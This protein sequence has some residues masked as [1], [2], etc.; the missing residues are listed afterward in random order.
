MVHCVFMKEL[1]LDDFHFEAISA[2]A[3]VL[4]EEYVEGNIQDEV[5][6]R[7]LTNK[8]TFLISVRVNM[9]L[10]S[11]GDHED[12]S[13]PGYWG[14]DSRKMS[15][16]IPAYMTWEIFHKADLGLA[17][18]CYTIGTWSGSMVLHQWDSTRDDRPVVSALAKLVE[19]GRVSIQA[20]VVWQ[21][22]NSEESHGRQGL[23]YLPQDSSSHHSL[24]YVKLVHL[25]GSNRGK[26]LTLAVVTGAQSRPAPSL[27]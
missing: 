12:S 10:F 1:T 15:P 20:K 8:G 5:G 17:A 16:S 2:L 27:R 24:V 18:A 26:L 23:D 3:S 14:S 22:W 4:A 6:V 13:M 25:H 11:Y 7:V 21:L 19:E 9:F